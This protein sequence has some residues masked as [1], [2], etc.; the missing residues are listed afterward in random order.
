MGASEVEVEKMKKR[1]KILGVASV[2]LFFSLAAGCDEVS[3]PSD[4]LAEFERPEALVEP[5]AETPEE[6]FEEFDPVVVEFPGWPGQDEQMTFELMWL[7]GNEQ[8]EL[9]E[10]PKVDAQVAAGGSW[11]DGDHFD[12]LQSLVVVQTPRPLVVVQDYEMTVTPFD[13]EE[14][15]LEAADERIRL[16]QGERIFLYRYQDEGSCYLGIRDG[17]VLGSCPGSRLE[18][19]EE[20]QELDDPWTSIDEKWWVKV[21]GDD[22]V[23]WFVVSEAPVEVHPREIEGY[24]EF[25]GAGGHY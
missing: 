18:P 15:E 23:G 8:L 12:W 20:P 11:F 14:G 21:E 13:T 9:R 17:V 19:E 25:D 5:A 22:G 2:G 7:G 24:D 10:A 16:E 4:P 1:W 3:E 6:E